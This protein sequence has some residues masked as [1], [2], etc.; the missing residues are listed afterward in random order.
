MYLLT[1]CSS[2]QSLFIPF[3]PFLFVIKL[4]KRCQTQS[5]TG[6]YAMINLSVSHLQQQTYHQLPQQFVQLL[7]RELGKPPMYKMFFHT[8]LSTI[9][10][11]SG[12]SLCY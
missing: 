7:E 6:L 12:E 9:R 4:W 5:P 3:P 1:T 2:Q 10:Q 8:S 11:I